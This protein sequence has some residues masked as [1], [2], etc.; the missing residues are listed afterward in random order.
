MLPLLY[1]ESGFKKR[2]ENLFCRIVTQGLLFL[3][4]K[5]K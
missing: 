3:K 1:K 5:I 4:E 2:E